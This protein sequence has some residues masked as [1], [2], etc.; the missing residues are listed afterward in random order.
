MVS[1]YHTRRLPASGPCH[2]SGVDLWDGHLSVGR[3]DFKVPGRGLPL[4]FQRTYSSNGGG[5]PGPLGPGWSHNWDSRVVITPCGD[6]IVIGGEGSGMRFVDDG[7][8]GLKP[9]KGYHG[10]LVADLA[11]F[12]FDF[13]S[14]DG[15][16]YH[17]I[18][19]A[20]TE[21]LLSWVADTDGNTTRLDYDLSNPY[22]P[23][24]KAVRDS[25]GRTLSFTYEVRQFAFW[26]GYVLTRVEGPDGMAVTF[27]YDFHGNL[28]R[29][30]RDE[31]AQVE[32]YSYALPPDYGLELRH[33]LLSTRN[34]LNGATTA[35]TYNLGAIGLQGDLRVPSYFVTSVTEPEGGVTRFDYDEAALE[36]RAANE[37]QISVT[38]PRDKVTVYRLNRYGSPL[39]IED[40]L[41]HKTT[42]TWAADDIVMT[43]R[44]DGNDVTTTYTYD[45]H[46]NQLTESIDVTD[47]DGQQHTYTI[48]NDYWFRPRSIRRTSRTG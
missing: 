22:E 12:S 33:K 20:G 3:D 23:L 21:F 28:A 43:S 37:L 26:G 30:A 16:R 29:A 42:M 35:Y 48:E 14:K 34:E 10:S 2:G 25:A 44:T 27:N 6:V 39:E 15:T 17:Y 18:H 9:L 13:Y 5:E 1:E 47:V 45:E 8:G 36:T 41:Q 46:G 38:D 31:D 19:G 11:S 32:T 24:L 40:P 4:S 7:A